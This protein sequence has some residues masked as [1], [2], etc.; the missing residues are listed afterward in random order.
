MIN[1]KEID[2]V[3]QQSKE[4]QFKYSIKRIADFEEIWVIAD[5][6]GIIMLKSS[7]NSFVLPVWPFKEFAEL[8]CVNEYKSCYPESISIYD[9]MENELLELKERSYELS[10]LPVHGKSS[11]VVSSEIFE[12]ELNVEM[13]KYG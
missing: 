8:F 7:T 12:K 1:V 10:I 5:D 13:N 9:F 11:I 4:V 2:T 3:V 6:S